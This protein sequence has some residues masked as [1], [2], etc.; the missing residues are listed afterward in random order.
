MKTILKAALRVAFC[1]AISLWLAVI[2]R[3]ESLAHQQAMSFILADQDLPDEP[4]DILYLHEDR[5]K[6]P[7]LVETTGYHRGKVGSH[8]DLMKKGYCAFAPEQYGTVLMLYEAI[9]TDSGYCMGDFITML[10]VKDTG[11]G[12]ETGEGKSKI[13]PDKKSKGTIEVGKS[14][15]VFYPTLSECKEWMQ[16]TNGMC[17]IQIVPG[18]G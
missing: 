2:V 9:P 16:Q 5:D 12:R 17:F 14:V 8:G 3:A 15:D 4:G 1:T 13:R 6:C 10:E 7:I 18:K 11:F